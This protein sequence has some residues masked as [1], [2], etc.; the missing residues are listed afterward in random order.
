MSD[1]QSHLSLAPEV[2]RLRPYR[3]KRADVR[4]RRAVKL[5]S[6]AKC[7]ACS[8]AFALEQL[9]A[10]RI[11]ETRS[12]P[13]LARKPLNMLALCSRCHSSVTLSEHFAASMLIHFYSEL[14]AAIRQRHHPFVVIHGLPALCSAFRT[15]NNDDW[16]AL[17]V[18][19]FT[20]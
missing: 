6:G 7:E 16:N 3:R 12:H 10:H 18:R 8:D 19:D 4:I 13:E 15:G 11:F 1:A 5:E 17:A 14:P 2:R 9:F 20:R